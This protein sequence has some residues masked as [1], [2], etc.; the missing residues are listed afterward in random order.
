M[1]AVVL[2]DPLRVVR[3]HIAIVCVIGL[4]L[5]CHIRFSAFALHLFVTRLCN[6][7]IIK[8]IVLKL[9]ADQIYYAILL[10]NYEKV[11]HAR[12]GR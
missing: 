7:H 4:I 6:E 12:S 9:L 2:H 8:Y 1:I 5:F 11:C 10:W 3:L